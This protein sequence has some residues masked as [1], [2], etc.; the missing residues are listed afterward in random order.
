MLSPAT[1]AA[2]YGGSSAQVQAARKAALQQFSD[3]QRLQQE[4]SFFVETTWRCTRRSC[5]R[6]GRKP[7]DGRRRKSLAGSS[8]HAGL[9]DRALN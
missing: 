2:V 9:V 6:T 1:R 3:Q 7:H 5:S 4:D 8:C